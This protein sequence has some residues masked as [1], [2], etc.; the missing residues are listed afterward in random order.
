MNPDA[1]AHA[2]QMLVSARRNKQPIDSLPPDLRPASQ[3][4]AEAIQD[5]TIELLDEPIGAWKVGAPGPQAEPSACP[6]PASL[7]KDGPAMMRASDY[8]PLAVEAELCF[9]VLHDLPPR[10]GSY[11]ADT[12]LYAFG[13]MRPAI[14]I[15]ASRYRD[16]QAVDAWSRVADMV[17]NGALVVGAFGV[18]DWRERDLTRQK[19][20]LDVGGRTLVSQDGGNTAGDPKRLLAWLANHAAKR[21]GG[22]RAGQIVTTGSFTGDRKSVV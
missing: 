18:A 21:V 4:D 1:I 15:V 16:W 14:E 13:M 11:D 6:I 19:V 20:R 12:A 2:A 5:M 3:A 22:L 10:A 9:R 17:N 8:P 7:V